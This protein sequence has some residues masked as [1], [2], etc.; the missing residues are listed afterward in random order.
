MRMESFPKSFFEMTVSEAYIIFRYRT[1]VK[2]RRMLNDAL[3]IG[4]SEESINLN[5]NSE[6]D[7]PSS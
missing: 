5:F 2:V 6:D 4:L 3:D 1:D 7:E